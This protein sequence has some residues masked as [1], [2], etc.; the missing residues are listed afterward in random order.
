VTEAKIHSLENLR[1]MP[2]EINSA[3]H[4]SQLRI[5][6]NR[7]YEPFLKT[8]TM[9]TEAQLLQKATELDTK[10]GTKFKPQAGGGQ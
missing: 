8:Q 10:F 2:Y 9:P 4:L 7:F 5:E 6:W 3:L 1:G